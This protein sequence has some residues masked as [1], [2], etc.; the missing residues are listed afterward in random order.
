MKFIKTERALRAVSF[1]L[2]LIITLSLISTSASAV[3]SCYTFSSSYK[4]SPYFEAFDELEL[5]GDQR[6]DVVAI[7][8]TQLGYHAGSDNNDMSGTNSLS[9]GNYVE[10][11]RYYGALATGYGYA[12][13]ASFVTWCLRQAG[14]PKDIAPSEISCGRMIEKYTAINSYT[15]VASGYIPKCGDLVFFNSPD[16]PAWGVSHVGLVAGVKDGMIYSIEGN[17]NKN[18]TMRTYPIGDS[19]I[20]GYGTPNYSCHDNTEYD[21]PLAASVEWYAPLVTNEALTVHSA[22][23]KASPQIA[24]VPAGTKLQIKYT[25]GFWGYVTYDGGEGWCSYSDCEPA[26]PDIEYTLKFISPTAGAPSFEVKKSDSVLT[27]PS[28]TPI[29]NDLVFLGWAEEPNGEVKYRPGDVYDANIS[30]PSPDD[31]TTE[32]PE[33]IDVPTR[34]LYAVWGSASCIVTYLDDKGEVIYSETVEYGSPTPTIADPIKADDEVFT[35]KF[36]GWTPALSPT[37]EGDATYTASFTATEK[38]VETEPPVVDT[39]APDEPED[40]TVPDDTGEI[41]DAPDLTTEELTTDATE[42]VEQTDNSTDTD[43]ENGP[44]GCASVTASAGALVVLILSC[45]ALAA[46][47]ERN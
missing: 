19:Y 33:K 10:Y 25:R 18:V 47:R 30:Q 37:V 34:F 15:T 35:Y 36:A 44:F 13:C 31:G 6:Y 14:V 8:Y 39:T 22:P 46:R 12:W 40:T 5:T 16:E 3:Q 41:T 2:F 26:L 28:A 45:V 23:G 29:K 21:F 7:A 42:T 20:I 27:I 1:V 43:G 32:A 9:F 17:A 38:P 24:T 4:S 11:N